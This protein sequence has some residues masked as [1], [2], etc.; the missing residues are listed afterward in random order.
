ML[1]KIIKKIKSTASSESF[2]AKIAK[3]TILVGAGNG[4]EQGF[5]FIRTVILTRILAPEAFGIVAIVYAANSAFE[6][7]FEIGVKEAIIQNP[8]GDKKT[9]LNGA[10][11]LSTIRATCIYL[12]L[13]FAA[14][15][16]A[17]FYNDEGLAEFLRVAFL[18]IL[19]NGMMSAN[20]Y[21][22]LKNLKYKKWV[23]IYNGGAAIGII[24]AICISFYIQNAWALIIGF[25]IESLSR[26][27]L[28]YVLCPFLPN[29][30]FDKNHLKSLFKYVKGMIGIPILVFIFMK[31]DI[32]IVGKLC[33]FT[34]LGIYSVVVAT[35]WFPFRL[36]SMVMSQITMPAFSK[37]QNDKERLGDISL[38]IT[39]AILSLGIPAFMFTVFYGSPTLELFY[40]N[41]YSQAVIPFSLIV[42]MALIRTCSLPIVSIYLSCGLPNL[43]RLFTAIRTAILLLIIYP[44][45]KFYG[46]NGAAASVCFAMIIS[47]VVQLFWVK[48]IIH[49]NLSEFLNIY[50]RIIGI[51]TLM[52]VFWSI[53]Y[54][55]NS[56]NA[57][58]N[59]AIGFVGFICIIYY[60]FRH[61]FNKLAIL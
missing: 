24:G 7:M 27:I 13:Y 41:Q 26:L 18:T 8:N 45:V 39:I 22:A 54:L 51:S 30:K 50:L 28:S 14:P 33:T 44:A 25:T 29:L 31:A 34:T 46:I 36:V 52:F 11:Y 12:I 47:Y 9:F 37:I 38:K 4:F 3:G 55:L 53:T 21:V 58:F 59:L 15:Y 35:A 2:K 5:R 61:Y 57:F 1:N 17:M 20:A 49:I 19:F 23:I 56:Q 10:W 60:I 6:A 48:K 43:H 40:G 32:F 42:L 16:I